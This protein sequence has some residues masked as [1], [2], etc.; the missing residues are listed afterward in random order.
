MKKVYLIASALC[1]GT[2]AFGQVQKNFTNEIYED[3][4]KGTES[5]V[6]DN[7]KS[8]V[9]TGGSTIWSEDFANGFGTS[10][11]T[12]GANGSVWIYDLSG[13]GGTYTDANI[14]SNSHGQNTTKSKYIIA[15]PSAANGFADFVA[16]EYGSA[17]NYP[18]ITGQLNSDT[19]DLSAVP[20]AFLSFYTRY[21][22]CCSSTPRL[23]V[24]VTTDGFTT[25]KSYE[26]VVPNVG[27]NDDSKTY[28]Y[29]INISDFLSTATNKSNFQFR[30]NWTGFD[31][32]FW[33]IDDISIVEAYSTEV[34]LSKLWLSDIFEVTE[35]P[36]KLG[37]TLTVQ[38]VLTNNGYQAIPT[39]TSL[40][41]E[42]LD[43]V[44][45]V[46]WTGT[47]GVLNSADP[48]N[49]NPRTIGDTITYETP[50]YWAQ[51]NNLGKYYV[52]GTII[53]SGDQDADNDTLRRRFNKTN[54]TIGQTVYE[55]GLKFDSPGHNT[56]SSNDY[57]FTIGNAFNLTDSL[58]AE[59]LTGIE[60]YLGNSSTYPLTAGTQIDA[61]VY[62]VDYS[63]NPITYTDLNYDKYFTIDA[64]NVPATNNYKKVLFN[65]F[66]SSDPSGISLPSVQ[67]PKAYIIGL[68][69]QGGTEHICLMNS[70]GDDDYSS[71]L[72]IKATQSSYKWYWN[73]DQ[74]LIN[75][76]FDPSLSVQENN[77]DIVNS[78]VY[79]NPTTGAAVVN[80]TLKNNATVTVK[81]VDVT[82]K[83]VYTTTENNQ[84]AGKHNV[85]IEASALN[86]GI[87]YVTI[88]NGD[89]QVTHKLIKK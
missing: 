88:A 49:G 69:H 29:S 2:V 77:I 4:S 62:E 71:R 1:V 34:Q 75:A 47:G 24:D 64:S 61:K 72:N 85:N 9:K 36:K 82:G 54:A 80:Y 78:N 51:A 28:N 55:T 44:N 89:S 19:I 22:Y 57:D 67:W 74:V 15:S 45:A 87:Y 8:T 42:V 83:V 81:V 21:R 16:D 66:Q 20:G 76:V 3:Y 5:N 13:P 86:A 53:V 84:V 60:V 56:T 11:T 33:Q 32:Y 59:D 30:F 35:V 70:Q 58:I 65:F 39:N 40:K 31:S 26:V 41:V 10:W 14:T 23:T 12:S 73:G 18:T 52:K 27:V 37:G 38:G 68:N 46:I 43:S 7:V 63:T 79:P 48:T 50:F 25:V 17:N 6:K